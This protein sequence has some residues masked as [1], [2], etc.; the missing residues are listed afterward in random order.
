[1][2]SVKRIFDM[3]TEYLCIPV[4]NAKSFDTPVYGK[5]VGNMTIVEPE[6]GG[7][8]QNCPVVGVSALEK[9]L[10]LFLKR[11]ECP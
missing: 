1:M 10:H 11:L 8:H 9:V 5:D 4:R 6:L 7:V 2:L 3:T